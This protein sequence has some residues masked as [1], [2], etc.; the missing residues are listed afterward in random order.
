MAKQNT[1]YG[2]DPNEY[3]AAV[4]EAVRRGGGSH[5]DARAAGRAARKDITA[6][7]DTSSTSKR[8]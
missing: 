7:S 2:I 8:K 3:A 5:D 6:H 4:A 1:P